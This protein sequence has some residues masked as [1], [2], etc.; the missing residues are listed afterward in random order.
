MQP[1]FSIITP[2][3]NPPHDAFEKCIESVYAQEFTNWQW[4]LVDDKSSD[5]YVVA[6]IK[7]LQVLDSRVVVYFRS[8]NGGIIEASNDALSLAMGEFVVLLDNDDV[9]HADAL[10]EVAAQIELDPEIDYIYTDEDK[11][12]VDGR[13]Y[14]EFKKPKWSPERLLAHNYCSHLSV[15]RR[16]LVNA[17]GRFRRGFEGSQDYDLILRVVEKTSRIA[18]IPKVLYHWRSVPGSVS[19]AADEKPYAFISATK[20]VTEHLQ[21][22]NIDAEVEEVKPYAISRVKR[23]L[24]QSPRISIIIPTCGTKKSLF[25]VDTCLVVNAVESIER[26]TSYKNYEIIVI[27]DTH[28]PPEILSELQRVSPLNLRI[29]NYEKEFNFSDKCN[30]GVVNSDTPFFVLLNDDTE[31]ISE[32]WLEIMLSYLQEPDVAA[33]GPM[34]LLE[35]GR[36]QSAGHSHTPDPHNFYNGR[37]IEE[38]GELGILKVARE[39]TGVTGACM[40]VRRNAY[41]EVG[42]MSKSFPLS[43][44]D[45]DL[46]FKFLDRGYRIIWTPF[47][48]LFHFETASRPNFSTQ[49]EVE[50]VTNRWGNRI[51]SDEYCRIE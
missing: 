29:V 15:I 7:E 21:R 34:L 42:G 18:H 26:K 9:L 10:A 12:T 47:V 46:S 5:P 32:D 36:I 19:I 44:N 45:V 27:A 35:D 11:V 4:C 28:T 1:L 17:V 38:L 39:C 48:R 16:E 22:K 20:A 13:H 33:V 40:M 3:Y 51:Y 2:V 50:L 31:V 30:L 41:F 14:D 25:G 6:R 23:R 49:K 43:F 37:S 8:E 24:K